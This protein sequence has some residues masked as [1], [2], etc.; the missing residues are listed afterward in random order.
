M[1]IYCGLVISNTLVFLNIS[2]GLISERWFQNR[3]NPEEYIGMMNAIVWLIIAFVNPLF[4]ISIDKLKNR[5][6]FVLIFI[7]FTFK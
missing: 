7:K 4:G 6:I 2:V 3:E 5:G 1:A